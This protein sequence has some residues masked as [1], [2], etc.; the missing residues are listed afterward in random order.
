MIEAWCTATTDGNPVSLAISLINSNTAISATNTE[1]TKSDTT[2]SI[3]QYAHVRI[4]PART[5]PA[6]EWQNPN[7]VGGAFQITCPDNTTLDLVLE[8]YVNNGDGLYPSVPTGAAVSQ[9]IGTV[10]MNYLDPSTAPGYFSPVGYN[11]FAVSP[12]PTPRPT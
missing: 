7:T 2:T 6:S 1:Q 11:S 8:V 3:D 4:M 12:T 5:S 9:P 10:V